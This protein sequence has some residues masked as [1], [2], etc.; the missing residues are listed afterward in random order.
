MILFCI[1]IGLTIPIF[2]KNELAKKAQSSGLSI[3][4]YSITHSGKGFLLTNVHIFSNEI[5]FD[6]TFKSV[7]VELSGLFHPQV[8]SIEVY[9]GSISVKGQIS[10]LQEKFEV[11][12]KKHHTTEQ[13]KKVSIRSSGITINWNDPG[14]EEYAVIKGISFN[15]SINSKLTSINSNLYM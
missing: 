5:P 1:G 7:K 11:W 12:K 15:N 13:R 2:V 6:A 9:D 14:K 8:R 3:T 10:D 4:E